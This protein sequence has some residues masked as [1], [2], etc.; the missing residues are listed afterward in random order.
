MSRAAAP[1]FADLDTI[2]EAARTAHDS[3][4]GEVSVVLY[5]SLARATLARVYADPVFQRSG[6]RLRI[7]VQDPSAAVR[8][9]AAGDAPDIAF[10][11]RYAGS[12]LAWPPAVHQLDLDPDSYRLIAPASWQLGQK[13]RDLPAAEVLSELP[14][15]L[16][17]PGTSDATV[18]EGVFRQAGIRARA[19]THSDSFDVVLDL[20]AAGAASAFVPSVVARLAPRGVDAFDVPGLEL[21]RDVHA[22]V[23]PSAPGPSTRVVLAA[24]QRALAPDADA[25]EVPQPSGAA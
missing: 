7:T 21:S 24:V 3:V 1:V 20:V 22:L 10:V 8:S 18:I 25:N 5:A 6:V 9:L 13:L 14:W 4:S 17:H 12:G 16:H 2:L 19:M 23:S 11:Y 15:A